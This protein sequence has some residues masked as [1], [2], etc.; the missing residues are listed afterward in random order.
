MADQVKLGFDK[1]SAVPVKIQADPLTL[2]QAKEILEKYG[3]AVGEGISPYRPK[4]N[5]IFIY[6]SSHQKT[7]NDW[8]AD[9]HMSR[10]AAPRVT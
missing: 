1:A 6:K 10:Y 9:G 3:Q 5:E 2:N 8:R 7:V 4:E